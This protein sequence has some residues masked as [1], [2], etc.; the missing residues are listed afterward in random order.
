MYVLSY[1]YII[2]TKCF[3]SLSMCPEL[4]IDKSVTICN[5][6]KITKWCRVV[7]PYNYV[8]T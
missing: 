5:M 1:R 4:L 2:T 8:L 3:M 7:T 6:W